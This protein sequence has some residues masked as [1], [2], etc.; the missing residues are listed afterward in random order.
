VPTP[1]AGAQAPAKVI[2]LGFGGAYK[3]VRDLVDACLRLPQGP[4]VLDLV[5]PVKRAF[6]EELQ[7]LAV[8]K[9]NGDWLRF[10]GSVS[11]EEALRRIMA[12]DLLVLASHGESAPAVIL[13]AMGCGKPVIGTTVGAI[14]E[15]LDIGG[16]QECGICVP[17]QD[18]AALSA[19][20]VEL[21]GSPEKRRI[22]GE[23]GRKRAET[24]YALPVG[25]AKLLDLWRTVARMSGAGRCKRKDVTC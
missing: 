3:G 5:G 2:F 6:Q 23:N 8:A 21:L 10:H 7:T 18:V 11:H 12:A 19:A 15:S 1:S 16:P 9:G 22:L 17:P 20:L 24:F 4:P 14:P 25:C 13:E